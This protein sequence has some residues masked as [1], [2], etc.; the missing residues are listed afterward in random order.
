MQD[1]RIGEK[2]THPYRGE[3]VVRECPDGDCGECV[4][5]DDGVICSNDT[6]MY[7]TGQCSKEYRIDHKD[8]I[9]IK[10]KGL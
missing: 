9:F 8:V 1:R 5:M 2:F 7:H 3:L 6:E 10:E 4:F